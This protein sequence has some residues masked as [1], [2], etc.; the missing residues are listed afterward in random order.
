MGDSLLL[1]GGPEAF[2]RDSG[3]PRILFWK[4]Q[5]KLLASVT[6]DPVT[7]STEIGQRGGHGL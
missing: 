3:C 5:E 7:L 4:H 2:E 6:V 1:N